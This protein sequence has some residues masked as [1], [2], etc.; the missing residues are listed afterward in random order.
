MGYYSSTGVPPG[1]FHFVKGGENMAKK[2]IPTDL[3]EQAAS[4]Q[5]AWSRIDPKMTLGSLNLTALITDIQGLRGIHADL[6]SMENQL[7]ALRD[8]R[9]ML[10]Q[11]TWD[12]VKGVRSMVKVIYGD[13]SLEYELMGGKRRSDR[14]PARRTPPS[15]ES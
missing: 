10:E 9:D 15:V 12:K 3:P 14:K 7:T 1:T 13:D 4:I 2:F 5:D 11:S 8:Q 6:V